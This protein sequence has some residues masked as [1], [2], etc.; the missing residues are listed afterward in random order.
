MSSASTRA[1]WGRSVTARSGCRCTRSG[2]LARCRLGGRCICPASGARS[3]SGGAR[4]R[5]LTRFSSRR[6]SSSG[7]SWSSAPVAG[8]FRGRR[9]SVITTTAAGAGCASGSIRLAASTCCRSGLSRSCSSTAPRLRERPSAVPRA[10]GAAGPRARAA[11]RSD[12]PARAGQRAD[13]QLPGGSRRRAGHRRLHPHALARRAWACA[14][15]GSGRSLRPRIRRR[16]RAAPTRGMADRR[17]APG[18]GEP[19]R[20]LALKP[21]R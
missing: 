13:C 5:S 3:Q 20:L 18:R 16:R 21:P 17:M 7:P 15:R 19:G 10:S 8:G 12:R 14:S 9:C 2:S 6:R 11:R 1:R 4:R